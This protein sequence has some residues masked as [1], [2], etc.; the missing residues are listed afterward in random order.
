MLYVF[1]ITQWRFLEGCD[2]LV[3]VVPK[4][5]FV[6]LIGMLLLPLLSLQHQ[7]LLMAMYVGSRHLVLRLPV[8]TGVALDVVLVDIDDG[9]GVP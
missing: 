3:Q 6:V 2:V 4:L 1:I 5:P 8:A 9:L 7:A